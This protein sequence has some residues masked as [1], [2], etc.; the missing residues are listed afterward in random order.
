MR[1]YARVDAHLDKLIRDVYPQPPDAGHTRWATEVLTR[2][3]PLFACEHKTL[4]DVGC[5]QGFCKPIVNGLGWQW[6]G[7]TVGEDYEACVKQGV[8]PVFQAD[9]T[10]LPVD[11]GAYD[12]VFARHVI[13]HSP[14][15]LV[16]L[17][18]WR[19]VM[20]S[21]LILVIPR[22]EAYGGGGR[23]HYYVLP[24]ANWQALI[25]FAG[26]GILHTDDSEPTEYRW[27]CGKALEKP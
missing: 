12:V 21:F 20:A 18:E 25:E 24:E 13:E 11:D 1:D 6:T 10:F 26:M 16:T 27:V 2:W 19:R 15:P 22:P 23:N 17:M 3:L 5:G 8:A 14:M 9:M 7:V 4:L